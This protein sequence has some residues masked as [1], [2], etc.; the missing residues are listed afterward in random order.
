MCSDDLEHVHDHFGDTACFK[1]EILHP[2]GTR[3]SSPFQNLQESQD[4]GKKY[5]KAKLDSSRAPPGEVTTGGAT[6]SCLGVALDGSNALRRVLSIF[7]FGTIFVNVQVHRREN[8]RRFSDIL[9]NQSRFVHQWWYLLIIHYQSFSGHTSFWTNPY[10]LHTLFMTGHWLLLVPLI[11]T[12]TVS[13]SLPCMI[14]LFTHCDRRS[15]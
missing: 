3:T 12:M 14:H 2:Q 15:D 9:P 13:Y 11:S 10:F 1:S 8:R 5:V 7:T 4:C 6:P